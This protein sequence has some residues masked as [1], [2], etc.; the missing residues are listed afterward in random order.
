M[1][2]CVY[3]YIYDTFVCE[4]IWSWKIQFT[5]QHC[6]STNVYSY[7]IYRWMLSVYAG[8]TNFES[9]GRLF[10]LHGRIAFTAEL[11]IQRQT[12]LCIYIHACWYPACKEYIQ[13]LL[14]VR[15]NIYCSSQS[16]LHNIYLIAN[17]IDSSVNNVEEGRRRRPSPLMFRVSTGLEWTQANWDVDIALLEHLRNQSK[18]WIR[19]SG[20]KKAT[21]ITIEVISY[22]LNDFTIRAS[23]EIYLDK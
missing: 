1:Y 23:E 14:L 12:R 11:A 16:A 18:C 21:E 19:T 4:K 17:E 6:L 7:K 22:L 13:I 20:E 9:I 10:I 5:A 15:R 2:V 3:I 8:C